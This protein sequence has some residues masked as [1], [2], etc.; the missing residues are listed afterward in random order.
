M[1]MQIDLKGE[2]QGKLERKVWVG[3]EARPGLPWRDPCVHR[4]GS[5]PS[6]ETIT[7]VSV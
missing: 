7:W 3:A 1:Q 2:V 4:A 6:M 5:A